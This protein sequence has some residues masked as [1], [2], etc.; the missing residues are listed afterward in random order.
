MAWEIGLLRVG[1]LIGGGGVCYLR[2]G[3]GV[4]VK[5]EELFGPKKN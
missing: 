3:V 2:V 1:L 4:V 5:S